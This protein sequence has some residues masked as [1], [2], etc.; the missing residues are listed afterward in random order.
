M[1]REIRTCKTVTRYSG[2]QAA[3][4]PPERAY[5]Q[6]PETVPPNLLF[7]TSGSDGLALVYHVGALFERRMLPAEHGQMQARLAMENRL[8]GTTDPAP[9]ASLTTANP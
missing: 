2:W 9:G 7:R 5:L 6:E 1:W 4:D 8:Q 3:E